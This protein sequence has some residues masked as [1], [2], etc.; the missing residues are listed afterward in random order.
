LARGFPVVVLTGPRQSGKTTLARATFPDKAYVS[1]EDP[2]IRLLAEDDPRG[3]LSRLPEGAI[4]DEIQRAPALFSYLQTRVDADSRPGLFVLT[5]SQQFGLLSGITQS[6]AGRAGIV[7]LLPFSMEE[8]RGANKLGTDADDLMFR[9]GYPPL[10]DRDI[11]PA[12]WHAGYVSTYLERDVRQLLAVRDLSA[13]QRFLKMCA[14]RTGQLVNLSSL[15]ADCGVTHGTAS[16]WMSVLEASYVVHLLRPH[17]RNF[18]KRLVKAPKLYFC[19]TGIAAWLLGIREPE[20]IRFHAQ[21]GA[22]FENL[23]VTEF[24]KGYLHRGRSP[25]LYFW[26]ESRGLEV[27]LLLEQGDRLLPIEVKA[28]ATL[29]GDSFTSLNRWRDLASAE[30][31]WLV[32]AGEHDVRHGEVDVVAWQGLPQLVDRLL[33]PPSL[34]DSRPR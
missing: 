23:V 3:L 11:R 24:L 27:D 28:G 6:L 19:D 30:Q 18:T 17:H 10:Y 31:A 20:Q 34:R 9:G 16:A 32:Y 25:D 15:A 29:A 5:G 12:D 2:D 14:A 26:R 33:Q 22:L 8:L 4:L 7:H 1:L 21:R 13:F